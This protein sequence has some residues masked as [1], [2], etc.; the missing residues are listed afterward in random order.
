MKKAV[1]Y[2]LFLLFMALAQVAFIQV[3]VARADTF[4]DLGFTTSAQDLTN[5]DE[6][7]ASQPYGSKNLTF[8]PKLEEYLVQVGTDSIT[9]SLEG[10]D[11]LGVIDPVT[12]PNS[13]NKYVKS[14]AVDVDGQGKEDATV[15]LYYRGSGEI[16][17]SLVKPLDN[18]ATIN[19]VLITM[20]A[21]QITDY[22][23]E[24]TYLN[25]VAGDFDNDCTSE[26]VVYVPEANNPRLILC[27]IENGLL[28]LDSSQSFSLDKL[29]KYLYM[30]TGDI[31]GDNIDDLAVSYSAPNI[32]NNPN[33]TD[34]DKWDESYYD[35]QWV[36]KI[37][38]FKSQGFS[39]TSPH[40]F[41]DL[42]NGANY[43]RSSYVNSSVA[44]GKVVYSDRKNRLLVAGTGYEPLLFGDPTFVHR[45]I[46]SYEYD[47]AKSTWDFKEVA[48]SSG[49]TTTKFL[50][51]TRHNYNQLT[52]LASLN[53]SA[54][55]DDISFY[56]DGFVLPSGGDMS[57]QYPY[58]DYG[59]YIDYG[60][61]TGNFFENNIRGFEQVKILRDNGSMDRNGVWTSEGREV[62][63]IGRDNSTY[64]KAV[65]K[66]LDAGTTC[67]ALAAPNTDDDT[68]IMKYKGYGLAYSDPVILAV[69]ASP[70][71]FEDL[72]NVAGGGNYIGGSST[73][74]TSGGG[75]SS[76]KTYSNTVTA[77]AYVSAEFTGGFLVFTGAEAE[78]ELAYAKTWEHEQVTEV[79]TNITYGT[80]GGQDSVALCTVPYDVF[81]YD[82]WTP[83]SGGNP[84]FWQTIQEFTPYTPAHT[85]V[86]LEQYDAIARR[87]GLMAVG[88]K[89]FTHNM[90]RPETYPGSREEMYRVSGDLLE[91]QAYDNLQWTE[92]GYGD[93]YTSQSVEI[94]N[95]TTD[96]ST[97]NFSVSFKIGVQHGW[98]LDGGNRFQL[99]GGIVGGYEHSWGSSKSSFENS[100]FTATVLNMPLEA[101]DLGF[102]YQYRLVP[103]TFVVQAGD[104]SDPRQ[105]T[106][107]IEKIYAGQDVPDEDKVITFP[108]LHY[109]VQGVR[110]PPLL[111]ANFAAVGSTAD[112]ITLQWD[113]IDPNA[114]GYQ[115][116]R[117]YD[118]DGDAA[119]YYKISD[120]LPAGVTTYTDINLLPYTTYKYKIQPVGRRLGGSTL[121]PDFWGV[122]SP[123]ITGRTCTAGDAPTINTQ[124][125]DVTVKAGSE[126]DFQVIV[127]TAAGA[128][129]TERI[130][131]SWQRYVDGRWQA[132][133]Q[134]DDA[135]L[136]IL[137]VKEDDAGL[138]RCAVSQQVGS[139][140]ITVYSGA[141]RLT[142]DKN[143]AALQL[144]VN[145]SNENVI[146]GF[147]QEATLLA[148]FDGTQSV[149]PAGNVNFYITYYPDPAEEVSDTGEPVIV[150][151]KSVT[152]Q[153]TGVIPDKQASASVKWAPKGY[154]CYDVEAVYGGDPNYNS[155][156][157]NTVGVTCAGVSAVDSALRIT[158]LD[159]SLAY[160]DEKSIG[161]TVINSGNI[162]SLSPAEVQFEFTADTG[163][164][165]GG[166]EI[167][168]IEGA[169]P[170]WQ[171]TAKAAGG[172][173]ITAYTLNP[174]APGA[175][176][177]QVAKSIFVSRA[178]VT[179]AVVNQEKEINADNPAYAV[180]LAEG[181]EMK[182]DDTLESNFTISYSCSAAKSSPAGVYPIFLSAK[183]NGTEN[184]D[185]TTQDGTLTITGPQYN[186]KFHGV[187][188]GRL[189]ALING[190]KVLPE[191]FAAGY[192]I[193]AGSAVRFTAVPNIGYRVEK[194]VVNGV[195]ALKDGSAG[196]DTSAY[197]TT[198]SLSQDV[199]V[200]VYFV[201]DL[202][203]LTYG[204][205]G[206]NG[207]LEAK[208]GS[209]SI[210]SGASLPSQTVVSFLAA[211]D[212]G[213][214]VSQ[215]TVDGTAV[216]SYTKNS[217]DLTV[218][219][220]T[221]VKVSF[222]PAGE[223]NISYAA[224]GN[225]RVTACYL[226]GSP[227]AG[228]TVAQGSDLVFT[229][230]PD[231]ENSMIK[232]WI[233][234]GQVV[235]GSSAVYT[236]ENIQE[237][238]DVKVVF[239]DAITY[240]VDF[241]AIRHGTDAL[242]A[243]VDGSFITSGSQ[244]KG[245]ADI[246][247]TAYPPA[248]YWVRQWYLGSDVV[249]DTGG[250]PLQGETYTLQELRSNVIVTVEFEGTDM[251]SVDYSSGEN[252]NLNARV[253]YAG[254]GSEYL[255]GDEIIQGSRVDLIAVPDPGYTVSAWTVN[256]DLISV[257]DAVYNSVCTA[258]YGSASSVYTIDSIQS[259]YN[260]SVDFARGSNPLTFA[261]LGSGTLTASSSDGNVTSGDLVAE[262]AQITFLAMPDEGC[263]VKEW[264][265]N[266]LFVAG[267]AGD[268]TLTVYNGG[269]VEVEFEREYYTLTLGKNLT[270]A[271]G[272]VDLQGGLAQGG[273]TVI[274]T[275]LPPAGSMLTAWYM[276]GVL[277]AGEQ[278]N[279]YSFI[280]EK[281]TGITADFGQHNYAVTFI[282]GE[283]GT[284]TASADGG[285]ISS[286]AEL[287]G[288]CTLVF[289]AQPYEGYQ[290]QAWYRD[291]AEVSG[292]KAA[293]SMTET[294]VIANLS[295]PEDISVYFEAIPEVPVV[296]QY[297]V[298]FSADSGG[299]ITARAD[300]QVISS[301]ASVAEGSRVIFIAQADSGKVVD[302][303]SGVE[304]GTLTD[305]NST[306]TIESLASDED[307][308]VTF[309]NKSSSGG[310]GGGGITSTSTPVNSTT[311]SA[312]VKPN[313]GGT[314]SL[315]RE[316][317][318][319][320]PSGALQGSEAEMVEITRSDNSP[321]APSGYML[322]G[323]AFSL[324]VGDLTTYT[325]NKPVTLTFTFDPSKVPAGATPSVFYY[326][327]AQAK[328]VSIGGSV[329]GN[330]IS[331]QVDH[332]TIFAVLVSKNPVPEPT[333]HPVNFAD[334]AGHWAAANINKLLEL[335]AASGYP[336]GTF[337]PDNTIT[338]AEFATVLVKA[339]KLEARQGKS[340]S[341]TSS[342]WA[343]NAIST[344]VAHGIISGYS[345]NE[346]GPDDLLTREQMAVMVVNAL[347]LSSAD[348]VLSY[349]DS[350]EISDWAKVA[351]SA[352][353]SNTIMGG[354][355]D[356]TFQPQNNATR[357]EAFT[358]ITRGLIK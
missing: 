103:Y 192:D 292:Q 132:V 51:Y 152:T 349:S 343:K 21:P 180:E 221:D 220:D 335:G 122:M 285:I 95:S 273:S 274:V 197:I 24:H 169:A 8:Y 44:I 69:L 155:Y 336:D 189:T 266:G 35:E 176:A 86:P 2:T 112:S 9:R 6:R 326:D 327:Q 4:S 88:G 233:V 209:V 111:P 310:G 356:N 29:T 182:F 279:T 170:Y 186:I 108:I 119:G 79:S 52:T 48:D 38:I 22:K 94:N 217:Y 101:Q 232:E 166:L 67:A 312:S 89:L 123:E 125:Q 54:R 210:G 151:P 129:L 171:L 127:Y 46:L 33:N 59:N 17:L 64:L 355:P 278:G 347:K 164:D 313:A 200:E 175:R 254:A 110:R 290:V 196:Y 357:A 302:Q 102:A 161:A 352:V 188:N 5:H 264:R 283:N 319:I 243:E 294:Y 179:I 10:D 73:E 61:V 32:Y 239:I 219:G 299:S 291:Q 187:S 225:G 90:G 262:G 206:S 66:P 316:V 31:T 50:N 49:H 130:F 142:V 246:T 304:N 139:Q 216:S 104:Y 277:I 346:F 163:S 275:A 58:T 308:Y 156:L 184:Y 136:R 148:A 298:K 358:V 271:V 183:E 303:W 1:F 145:G 56:C 55:K 228:N 106:T 47:S 41:N 117:Y 265:Y 340:F 143:M 334:V 63:T 107:D 317:S 26:I 199:V 172:Y 93:A 247:F 70:P 97:N 85:V 286:G 137:A 259:S 251:Y 203:A 81:S 168:K 115:L 260:I 253:T 248:G 287:P 256:G 227:L 311:G 270:A 213:Y 351:V 194:W 75:T 240:T 212:N 105:Y 144:T 83:A 131:Y 318:V 116:Y 242:T 140:A 68:V 295:K 120:V 157:S 39:L 306:F 191:D 84:G 126:A 80:F 167:V 339:F 30:T 296:Q 23:F 87:D 322:L 53:F 159:D 173:K 282:A 229:A 201:P 244:V 100:G 307:V 65:I 149:K 141:A 321:A 250:N 124:P 118:F 315:G 332:F 190:W 40:I 76:G 91:K 25:M 268:C 154:G 114:T 134:G 153:L 353:V 178:P 214:M 215:W 281:D 205:N 337:R 342:H 36:R 323:Q 92:V 309:K 15:E 333:Q 34:P 331:V 160:G 62:A 272:G 57:Q 20:S 241:S 269:Y 328:W 230:A 7:A 147:D 14:V 198:G 238:L 257:C 146:L 325:F 121:E 195:E 113:N 12:Q 78:L 267:S 223:A 338:R 99:S 135:T 222:A 193:A 204:V 348:E 252:G 162:R 28:Q 300:G 165:P 261:A 320:I 109:A 236:A 96:T 211:P 177:L 13:I 98:D 301:G 27:Q 354:Y 314:I 218:T 45:T 263:Q 150:Y 71:Y 82:L 16:W 329:S 158:G 60:V 345:D 280:M 74:F 305:D 128:A 37:Y 208:V 330:T 19:E 231:D 235:L 138:Y 42:N 181:T 255:S 258:V 293:D 249:L 297:F 174:S 234:N 237:P 226:G 11:N 245:Y 350:T 133:E 284:I 289:T 18:F 341:D 202:C 288:G 224:I 72:G 3:P 276:D 185:V 77:G 43:Y 324:T 344:A 207:M